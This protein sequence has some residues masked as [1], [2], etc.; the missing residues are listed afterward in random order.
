MHERS[1]ASTTYLSKSSVN[2]STVLQLLKD[3]ARR[4]AGGRPQRRLGEWQRRP[5]IQIMKKSHN[6][7]LQFD[8]GTM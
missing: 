8:S 7:T 3:A 4:V 5:H 1:P 2:T 6:L